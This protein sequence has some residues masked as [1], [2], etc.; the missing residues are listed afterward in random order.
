MLFQIKINS[1]N[2]QEK[3]K[4]YEQKDYQK[5]WSIHLVFLFDQSIFL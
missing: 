4:Q 3:L 2:Y 1:M 5:I